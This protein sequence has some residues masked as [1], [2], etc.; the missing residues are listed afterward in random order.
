MVPVF[1][2]LRYR[3]KPLDEV[4]GYS[5]EVAKDVFEATRTAGAQ[6]L[7]L[8]KGAG[9]AVGLAIRQVVEA[10]LK[11]SGEWLPVSTLHRDGPFAGVAMSVPTRVGRA[12]VLEVDYRQLAD[13]E[14]AA[15]KQS[16]EVLRK[17][18]G[19]LEGA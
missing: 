1:S 8:K 5:Q 15:L 10:V 6:C 12:G 11:D 18:I 19:A 9:Y 3:G 17:T 2:A 4:P 13:S 7:R 16:A 14:L